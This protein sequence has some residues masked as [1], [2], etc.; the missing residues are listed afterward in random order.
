[1]AVAKG[2]GYSSSWCIVQSTPLPTFS[3]SDRDF[4]ACEDVGASFSMNRAALPDGLR[5]G[6]GC[7]KR[8]GPSI[9]EPRLVFTAQREAK[10]Q[11]R[12]TFASGPGRPEYVD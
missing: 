7:G 4:S 2:C 1:V 12:L 8:D 6:K 3:M 5:V 9:P 11:V 10:G